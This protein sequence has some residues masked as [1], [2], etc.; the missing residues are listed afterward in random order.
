MAREHD[1]IPSGP[2]SD[3]EYLSRSENRVLL[4]DA[5][6]RETKTRREL[7]AETGV[8]RA[9]LD[10][11][12]NELEERGWVER[13]IDGEYVTTRVGSALIE[14]F[15]PFLDSVKTIRQLG[16]AVAWL[17]DE[18]SIGLEHFSDATVRR[19]AQDDPA[20]TGT[21]FVELTERA[22]EMRVITHLVPPVP[23]AR[24]MHERIMEG[25]LDTTFVIS[26]N[27]IDYL[28]D[29]PER[30]DRW[31]EMIE[32]GARV[33]ETVLIKQSNP[34]PIQES[35][36]VPIVSENEA[37]RS[38]ATDLVEQYR[39]DATP[40]TAEVFADSS[41]LSQTGQPPE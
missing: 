9:T 26:E 20:E 25:T 38:W 11:I 2:L 21:Y 33:F 24:T 32:G 30:P 5:L 18:L 40:V 7:E 16:Y 19:P 10:R 41:G 3:V 23:L 27:T 17:P 28:R 34:G 6:A 22:T 36:G 14:Q 39:S 12:V 15:V 1:G 4:L 35:Y 8:S 29:R 37:V 13:T 31:H